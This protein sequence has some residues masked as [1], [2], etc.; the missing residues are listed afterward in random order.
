MICKKCGR[1]YDDDMP[2]CLWCDAPN[3]GMDEATEVQSSAAE[4]AESA[5]SKSEERASLA[6]T[7][8]KIFFI[9]FL[10]F[11]VSTEISVLSFSTEPFSEKILKGFLVSWLFAPFTPFLLLKINSILDLLAFGSVLNFMLLSIHVTI[12]LGVTVY[13]F[14]AWLYD[15][16]K[17]QR[18]FTETKVLPWQTIFY[19]LIPF[20][21]PSYNQ[22]VFKDLLKN[23]KET[24][25]RN[26][27]AYK[28]LPRW[29][30]PVISGLGSAVQIVFVIGIFAARG[31]F[32]LRVI[33]LVLGIV[34]FIA[35]IKAIRTISENAQAL[36]SIQSD[37]HQDAGR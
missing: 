17:A 1:E 6:I 5:T 16:V 29:V 2:K 7:W 21:G 27:L 23:Q 30:L 4:P 18:R 8:L 12:I 37:V 13:K 22:F 32:A 10:I 24:L 11:F 36:E 31:I 3:D 34:V 26:G 20:V 35:Y 15:T 28:G 14:C 33:S 25:E 19:N 9:G